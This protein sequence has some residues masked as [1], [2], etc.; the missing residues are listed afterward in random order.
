LP[1]NN[2][3]ERG[4]VKLYF[5]FLIIDELGKGALWIV[6]LR[7]EPDK[8]SMQ[9]STGTRELQSPAIVTLTESVEIQCT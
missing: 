3:C 2:I 1:H 6:K 5:R 7:Y 4:E 9:V 8:Q